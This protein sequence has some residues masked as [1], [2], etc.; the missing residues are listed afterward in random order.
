MQQFNYLQFIQ[1]PKNSIIDHYITTNTTIIYVEN[2]Q[3]IKYKQ[4]ISLQIFFDL[5]IIH[6]NLEFSAPIITM[7]IQLHKNLKFFL[8]IWRC[9]F[10]HCNYSYVTYY[11]LNLYVIEDFS[12]RSDVEPVWRTVVG[13]YFCHFA[14]NLIVLQ[15]FERYNMLLIYLMYTVQLQT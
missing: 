2:Y 6:R 14:R 9:V 10:D 11:L 3:S 8:R 12:S 13:G 5:I 1:L 15:K 4:I 7:K